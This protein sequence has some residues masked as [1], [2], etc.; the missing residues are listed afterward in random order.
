[1]E[2]IGIDLGSNS[3]RGVRMKV[4]DSKGRKEFI[5]LKEYD[6]TVRTAE[7]L[8]ESGVICEQ[9][10]CR[11]INGLLKMKEVLEISSSDRVIALT[12][13]AM[14]RAKNREEVLQE[15]FKKSGIRFRIINGEMEAKI[16]A[17]AP[18]LALEKLRIQNSKYDRDCFLLIDMGGASSEFIVCK[19]M[20]SQNIE[21]A[22]SFEIGIVSAKD[23]FK[24]VE[25][26]KEHKDVF[27]KEIVEFV[28]SCKTKGMIPKFLVANSGT[29]TLVCAFKLGLKKYDSKAVFGKSLLREDFDA[30]L[31]SFLKLNKEEQASLVGEF[32]ADVVPFG[33]VLFTCFMEALGFKECLVIDEGLREG[34]VIT[35]ALEAIK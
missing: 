1:M 19:N 14:R 11:I 21:F 24:S 35:F 15:I 22:K 31:R 32:K 9:A 5:A 28:E 16:T 6:C 8:E 3:L 10:V 2:I 27:L 18:K 13:Q 26:L 25:S 20:E 23:R 12:T 30:M 4:V 34:A 17:L 29:P 33:V 7:E